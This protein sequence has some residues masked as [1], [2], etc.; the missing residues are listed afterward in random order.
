MR[1]I[2]FS[3]LFLFCHNNISAVERNRDSEAL[4]AKARE[5]M[6]Q[7]NRIARDLYNFAKDTHNPCN[8]EVEKRHSGIKPRLYHEQ[9]RVSAGSHSLEQHGESMRL[10]YDLQARYA[11][12]QRRSQELRRLKEEW[13][14]NRYDQSAYQKYAAEQEEY[15][16][17]SALYKEDLER[18]HEMKRML[19]AR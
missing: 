13:T 14:S 3:L 7:I 18:H 9:S 19:R 17:L 6:E 12:L 16:R 8:D 2:I 4:D 10:F 11:D 1:F 5:M 15:N